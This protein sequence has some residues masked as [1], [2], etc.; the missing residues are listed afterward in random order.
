MVLYLHSLQTLSNRV[1][2]PF[3]ALFILLFD[4]NNTWAEIKTAAREMIND[5]NSES[6]AQIAQLT[7]A[8]ANL[9]GLFSLD[10]P[11]SISFAKPMEDLIPDMA[12]YNM[13]PNRL[14]RPIT[15]AIAY[16]NRCQCDCIY[17][18]AEREPSQERSLDEW[19][20]V[21]DE[22][23]ENDV[24]LVDI[25]GADIFCRKDAFEILGELAARNFSFF[26]STKS[27]VTAERARRLAALNIGNKNMPHWALRPVQV[28]LD[29]AESEQAAFLTR[30]KNYL[31][32]AETS[33]KN[34]IEA[35]ARPRMKAVLTSYNADASLNIVRR[36][37]PMGVDEF[38]FVQYCRGLYRHSD[39]IFSSLEQ[40]KCLTDIERQIKDEFPDVFV[41]M[42][43]DLTM[44]GPMNLTPD[45]WEKRA[46][47]S[48]GRTKMLVKPNGDVTLCEQTP[49]NGVFVVGNVFEQG[50]MGVWNSDAIRRF[51]EP[52]RELFKDTVCFN[53]P[54][55]EKCHGK[56]GWCFRDSL[57]CYGT[58]YEA[59]PDCPWQN[60]IPPRV[61]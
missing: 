39:D 7:A 45:A 55:F 56:K 43:K 10:G 2:S 9:R 15:I 4:G 33:V 48:G 44:A 49:G 14:L 40:K 18:Y 57:I 34:L 11:P 35:G 12:N 46:A 1:L 32:H 42:Q 58:I 41:S 24:T 21:F 28:S 25:G 31:Q 27:L 8:L 6:D 52:P 26:V 17:C 36:F 22:L 23:A 29:S 37:A 30:Q 59:P 60:K 16:T 5:T 13:S 51:N 19:T 20:R 38:H 61:R 50:V 3:E 47:C 53:C 54:D